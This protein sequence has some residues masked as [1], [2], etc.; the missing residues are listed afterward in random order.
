MNLNFQ[1]RQ[2]PECVGMTGEQ[3]KEKI[4][5][6]FPAAK[7]QIIHENTPCTMDLRADRVRVVTD[8]NGKVIHAPG[9]G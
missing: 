3:A 6:D 1:A 7:V 2:W 9:T 5:K 8:K 4:L